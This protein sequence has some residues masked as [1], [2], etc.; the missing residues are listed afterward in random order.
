MKYKLETIPV[1]DALKED[2]ECPLCHLELKMT[3]YYSAY[4][5]GSSVM[6]PETRVVVNQKGFCHDHFLGLMERKKAHAL[7]LMTHTHMAES[8]KKLIPLLKDLQNKGAK[9]REKGG[10]AAKKGLVKS[11]ESL[12]QWLKEKEQS[13]LICEGIERT[14]KRYAF[15]IAWLWKDD[16]EF[17]DAFR[18]SR[19]ICL[20]HMPLQIDLAAEALKDKELGDFLEALADTEIKALERLDAELLWFTQKFDSQNNDKDW[21]TSKDAHRR[22]IQKIAGPF[23]KEN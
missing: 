9:A 20:H 3:D 10:G 6:N 11:R 7:G 19:G 13:C 12:I 14:M 23:P 5:L 18:S 4:Y 1:W 22:S 17:R 16:E 21:G 15:T 2:T 8:R